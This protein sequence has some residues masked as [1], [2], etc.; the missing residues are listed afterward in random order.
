M[1]NSLPSP[2]AVVSCH[3]ERPLDDRAWSLFDRL[4]RRRPGGFDVIALLRPPDA[5]FDEA[6]VYGFDDRKYAGYFLAEDEYTRLATLDAQD[7]TNI[8]AKA[9]DL[10]P[11]TWSDTPTRF[12]YLGTY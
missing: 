12:H 4:Q 7:E 6:D 10:I 8:G 2:S 1:G 9:P 5:A 3:V 11:P